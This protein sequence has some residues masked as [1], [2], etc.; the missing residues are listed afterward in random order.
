MGGRL[1]GRGEVTVAKAEAEAEAEAEV[2]A[3]DKLFPCANL[4]RRCASAIWS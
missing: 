3:E 2:E 4:V 1:I